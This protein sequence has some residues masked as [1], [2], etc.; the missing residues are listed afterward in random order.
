MD[1][2]GFARESHRRSSKLF[3]IKHIRNKYLR[4]FLL[5]SDFFENIY[6]LDI[7]MINENNQ[8]NKILSTKVHA[9]SSSL[10]IRHFASQDEV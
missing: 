3:Y 2:K 8:T 9:I 6:H 7:N 5:R 1:W 4:F 10:A